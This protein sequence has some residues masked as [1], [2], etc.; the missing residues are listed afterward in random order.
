VKAGR[1]RSRTGPAPIKLPGLSREFLCRAGLVTV[2]GATAHQVPWEWLRF[3]TSECVLRISASLGM[4]TSRVTFDTI[5][6]RG[7]AFQFVIACTFVDVFMGSIPLLWDL[8]KSVLRNILWLTATATVLFGFNVVRLEAAQ[9]LYYRGMSWTVADEVLGGL[10]YFAV[11]LAIWR[12]R[13]WKVWT[14]LTEPD[15][16][17]VRS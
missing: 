6:A 14:S 9:V 16:L 2:F 13:S 15:A 3:L 10:A 5:L 17:P 12:L 1:F 11:W 7:Q 4:A 8:K